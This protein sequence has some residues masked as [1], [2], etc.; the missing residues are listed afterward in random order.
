MHTWRQFSH[1]STTELVLCSVALAE[2]RIVRFV[3]IN[4]RTNSRIEQSVKFKLCLPVCDRYV[5]K[6]LPARTNISLRQ[7]F[8][9]HLQNACGFPRYFLVRSFIILLHAKSPLPGQPID[10]GSTSCF[11]NS[12]NTAASSGRSIR[13]DIMSRLASILE[14][15][16]CLCSYLQI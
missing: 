14:L 12:L 9:E 8:F 3:C 6:R 5:K 2:S 15:N 10:V 7:C 13:R 16:Y 4:S 1:H 11:R